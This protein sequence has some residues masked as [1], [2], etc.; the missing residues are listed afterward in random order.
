MG[1]GFRMIQ[2]HHIVFIYLFSAVLSLPC[3]L[4]A[5]SSCREWSL[6]SSCSVQAPHCSGFS[7]CRA[8]AL[9]MCTS[10]V[11]AL[12]LSPSMACGIVPDQ[13]LNL[14]PLHWQAILIHCTSGEV[15]STLHLLHTLFL[16]LLDQ[17]HFRSSGI[18]SWF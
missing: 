3:Y 11:V 10:I 5:F 17:L 15:P 6:F 18:R 8:R 12:R 14:C 1:D 9:G 7:C 13:E 4:Q 16:L 2:A